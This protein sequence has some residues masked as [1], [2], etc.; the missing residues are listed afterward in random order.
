MLSRST[1]PATGAGIG[2]RYRLRGTTGRDHPDG[3]ETRDTHL[4]PVRPIQ[5]NKS[6]IVVS[7]LDDHRPAPPGVIDHIS[8][9]DVFGAKTVPVLP[10]DNLVFCLSSH[11]NLLDANVGHC[12]ELV[13]P[14]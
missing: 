2:G 6:A 4:A 1:I 7:S 14:Y 9:L 10:V 3:V 12:P 11:D 8:S 13:N 5:D